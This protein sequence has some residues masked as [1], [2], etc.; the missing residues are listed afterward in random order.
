MP[1]RG[2]LAAGLHRVLDR[3]CAVTEER[4]SRVDVRD[5]VRD[6]PESGWTLARFLRRTDDLDDHLAEPEEDLADR[7]SAEFAVPFAAR[8]HTDSG[9]R[10]DRPTQVR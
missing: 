1:E 9:Q 3:C 2:D 4:G 5:D 8:L 7:L 10:F 6:P